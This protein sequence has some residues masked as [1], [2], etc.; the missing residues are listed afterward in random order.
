MGVCLLVVLQPVSG[1]VS[2]KWVVFSAAL[3][4]VS[5]SRRCSRS[6]PKRRDLEMMMVMFSLLHCTLTPGAKIK[7]TKINDANEMKLLKDGS[8]SSFANFSNCLAIKE[9]RKE[10][11]YLEYY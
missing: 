7:K 2:E 11:T 1:V 3:Q 9:C 10:I 4:L 8:K 6:I 5:R